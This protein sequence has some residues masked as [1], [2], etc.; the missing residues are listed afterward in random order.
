MRMRKDKFQQQKKINLD[1]GG[2]GREKNVIFHDSLIGQL[3]LSDNVRLN[4]SVVVL[5]SPDE[6]STGLEALGHHIVDQTVLIPDALLVKL[7]GILSEQNIKQ[8]LNL[9]STNKRFHVNSSKSSPQVS[10]F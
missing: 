1:E 5:A 10:M 3:T 4:I 2:G 6:A 7:R 8:L 9:L